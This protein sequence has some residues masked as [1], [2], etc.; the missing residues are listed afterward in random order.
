MESEPVG[1]PLVSRGKPRGW[2]GL[3]T[4]LGRSRE[5]FPNTGAPSLREANTV[6]YGGCNICFNA[7]PAKFYLEAGRVIGVSGNDDD[8]HWRGRC[9]PKVQSQSALFNSPHR[10][11][12]PLKRIGVRGEGKF[13]RVSWEQAL[14]ELAE[15]LIRVRDEHGAEALAI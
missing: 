3:I 7:C 10:L 15:R 2:R 9:C 8:P 4:R 5:E 11:L 12:H 6:G 13:E 14:D 1:V